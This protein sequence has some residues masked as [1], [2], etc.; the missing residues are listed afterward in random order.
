MDSGEPVKCNCLVNILQGSTT[1]T[2]TDL[3]GVDTQTP[4]VITATSPSLV[5]ITFTASPLVVEE[6]GDLHLQY[7]YFKIVVL[8]DYGRSFAN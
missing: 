5:A 6:E 7:V 4:T 3:I 8:S 1:I 2:I